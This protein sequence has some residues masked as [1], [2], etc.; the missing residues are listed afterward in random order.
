MH[1][2][3]LCHHRVLIAAG[4]FVLVALESASGQ[5]PVSQVFTNG[6]LHPAWVVVNPNP[7]STHG[8]VGNALKLV[9]SWKNGG[10]DFWSGSNYNGLRML[11]SVNP[12]FDWTMVAHVSFSPL[13]N[14][15]GVGLMIA[16]TNG[17]FVSPADYVTATEYGDIGSH[18]G[19]WSISDGFTPYTGTSIYLRMRKS[20]TNFATAWSTDGTNWQNEGWSGRAGA[21]PWIGVYVIR[22]QFDG[23]QIDSTVTVHSVLF[24]SSAITVDALYT[25]PQD[26]RQ[27][28]PVFLL[29]SIQRPSTGDTTAIIVHARDVDSTNG[30]QAIPMVNSG[31]NFISQQPF[32]KQSIGSVAVY[33]EALY[34]PTGSPGNIYFPAGGA[35]NP[36]VYPVLMTPVEPVGEIGLVQ[37]YDDYVRVGWNLDA[38][39][40][41]IGMSTGKVWASLVPPGDG[42]GRIWKG[43]VVS[44][45]TNLAILGSRGLPVV[46]PMGSNAAGF[47]R[48]DYLS[49]FSLADSDGDGLTDVYEAQYPP[50]NPLATDT[51]GGDPDGDGLTT[52]E[53]SRLG[54]NP[55]AGTTNVPPDELGL[56]IYTPSDL[57]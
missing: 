19:I 9:A 27:G 5:V 6:S 15:Q 35:N 17:T 37:L 53:E 39:K 56:I 14:H 55:F 32:V 30:Y 52:L 1:I 46:L 42:V 45:I 2:D 31:T 11:Q 12:V 57:P 43:D 23:V 44:Q 8:F 54:R 47:A 48:A 18:R 36:L 41:G 13:Y 34:G 22:Q 40:V 10:S 28:Q 20:S 49:P 24:E 51:S 7:D 50:L 4:L 25:D 3:H 38:L 29:A 16:K 33:V 21:W 26:P